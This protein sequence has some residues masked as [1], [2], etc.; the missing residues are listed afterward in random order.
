MRTVRRAWRRLVAMFTHRQQDARF[1]EELRTHLEMLVEEKI[2]QGLDPADARREARLEFGDVE[3]VSDSCR[4]ERGYPFVESVVRDVRYA[5][6]GLRRSPGFAL[7]AIS[8]LA[9]GIGAATALFSVANAALLRRLPVV[10]PD[11]LVLLRWVSENPKDLDLPRSSSGNGDVSL[12][13]AAL[14]AFRPGTRTLAGVVAYASLGFDRSSVTVAADHRTFVASGE[15]VSGNYFDVLGVG[16][17]IGRPL[18]KGADSPAAPNEVVLSHAF[19]QREFGGEPSAIGASLTLNGEAFTVVGVA[20]PAFKGLDPDNAPDL[21]VP[22]RDYRGLRPWGQAPQKGQLSLFEDRG[23]FWCTMVGRLRP[24][25]TVQALASELNP[26]FTRTITEGLDPVPPASHLP[27]L[28][29]EPVPHGLDRLQKRLEQPLQVVGAGVALLLLIACTN[30]ATLLL[31]R[32]ESRQ[33]EI[34]VRLSIGASR[35]RVIQQLLIEGLVLAAAGGT[36]GLLLAQWVAPV[37]LV[38][39]ARAE[40]ATALDAHVDGIVLAFS[41]A[42][43]LLTGVVFGLAPALAATRLDVSSRLRQNSTT[44]TSRRARGRALV[45]LQVAL[46]VMLL[47][48]AGLFVRTLRNLSGQN[49]G[50]DSSNLLL[51]QVEPRRAGY[52]PA[53]LPRV[54]REVLE[55]VG[56][57][58][59]V[60]SATFSGNAL[61]TGWSSS[62]RATTENGGPGAPANRMH[63]NTVG[64]H[65]TETIGIPL[66]LGRQLTEHDVWDAQRVVVVNRS[67]ASQFFPNSNP[68]GHRFSLG[69]TFDPAESYE[70]V[71]VVEDAKYDRLRRDTPPTVYMP[72]TTASYQPARIWIQLRTA[73]DPTTLIPAI[74]EAV[75]RIDNRLPLINV[76][77]QREQ[78]DRA[79]VEERMFASVSSAFSALA[80]VLVA[81]GLFGTLAYT[82]S[83]RTS[84]IGIRMALG[85]GAGDVSFMVLREAA[86]IVGLGVILGLPPALLLARFVRSLLFG[87]TPFDAL[88]VAG[89]VGVIAAIGLVASLPPSWRAARINPTTALRAE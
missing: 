50:F 78:M 45:A 60:Q 88:T 40:T 57:V 70:I 36:A 9:L 2:R 37:L 83:R 65:Y 32:S 44:A 31:A 59:G 6:R 34:G 5:V 30:V 69:P 68:L 7:A 64:P 14:T 13:Y 76:R 80:L 11:E 28:A 18:T 77:T 54:Y 82:V 75:S 66:V 25:A 38:L 56:R 41:F 89:A 63:W 23:Y 79:L 10:R 51:F 29:A 39:L 55:R 85:A 58:P 49:L 24:G 35:P 12:P 21:W 43:S 4:D 84:E 26:V 46:S 42:V 19:W 20:P 16:A 22:M 33:K 72:L 73:G 67:W 48:G 71:G 27:R 86:T 81:A 8:C 52:E 62:S 74:R 3:A 1:D 53:A 47:L 17:E 61:L 15:M 87:V